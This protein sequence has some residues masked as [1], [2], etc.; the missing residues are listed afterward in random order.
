MKLIKLIWIGCLFLVIQSCSNEPEEFEEFES[1]QFEIFNPDD[2]CIQ[3]TAN[4]LPD[5]GQVMGQVMDHLLGYGLRIIMS[6]EGMDLQIYIMHLQTMVLI[7][8]RVK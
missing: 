6:I 2:P 4:C 7:I 5:D 1:A 8:L 3:G